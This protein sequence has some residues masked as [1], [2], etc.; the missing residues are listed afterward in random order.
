MQKGYPKAVLSPFE[1]IM[2]ILSHSMQKIIICDFLIFPGQFR[3]IIDINSKKYDM[4]SYPAC[5]AN[6]CKE[7]K[8][9]LSHEILVSLL[10]FG[11]IDCM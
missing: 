6:K 10:N 8:M 5:S 11:F 1:Q 3:E 4:F 2:M 7:L 9:I